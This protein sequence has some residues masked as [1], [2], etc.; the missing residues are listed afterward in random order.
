MLSS[1]IRAKKNVRARIENFLFLFII[2]PIKKKKPIKIGKLILIDLPNKPIPFILGK[3]ER[4]VPFIWSK[5][6][7]V[8]FCIN[9]EKDE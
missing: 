1:N 7:M 8:A 4:R 9:T 3:K 2:I 6:V 5:K